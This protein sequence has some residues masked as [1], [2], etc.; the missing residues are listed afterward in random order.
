MQEVVRNDLDVEA[1]LIYDQWGWPV[2]DNSYHDLQ[3]RFKDKILIIVS[4]RVSTVYSFDNILVLNNG[5]IVESG[6][7]DDL[8]KVDGLFADLLKVQKMLPKEKVL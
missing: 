8:L 2:F 1:V 5:V 3:Q 6:N 4:S 7:S